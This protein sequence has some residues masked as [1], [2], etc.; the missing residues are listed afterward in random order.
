MHGSART[1][2]AVV[3]V[4]FILG[5][6]SGWWYRGLTSPAK[7]SSVVRI[8]EGPPRPLTNPAPPSSVTVQTEPVPQ[9]IDDKGTLNQMLVEQRFRDATAYYYQSVDA[10]LESKAR[11][12]PTVDA[13]LQ[14][15]FR[16]CES[17]TFLNLVDAWLATFYD[18]VP[19]LIALA[20]FQENQGQPEAAANTLLL[21]RTYAFPADDR[22]AVQQAL[23]RLTQRTDERLAGE[24]RW[25]ELLG[26]Y[27]FLAAIDFTA[28][29]FEL[30]RALLYRR[31]GEHV[32]A[33]E[34][35]TAL[36]TAD[37][38]SNPQLTAAIDRNI[39]ETT[40]ET[41]AVKDLSHAI[42][43]ERRGNG[44]L[45]NITLNDRGSLKLLV[46]TGASM[47]AISRETFR[48]LYQPDFRL[49]G[50]QLF[51]T[52]NGYTRGNV[53]RASAL[54]LGH[55]RL[56]DID[57]AVLDLQTLGDIDGLFGMNVLREFHFEID[58]ATGVMYLRRR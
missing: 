35:L 55:E 37:D 13:Y 15:C 23:D 41:K 20:E 1:Y 51:N 5:V 12:R 39:A 53:Y 14:H 57:V 56:N 22:S 33:T 9:E 36:K 30:R 25:V 7:R 32:R 47:T 45:V 11:L 16:N 17:E 26:Y 46:D 40:E 2:L 8:I 43:L 3:S 19:V 31:L 48:R 29:R 18:D 52:A 10:D 27:E 38:G 24:Q 49:V 54:N 4:V 50:T 58:H 44:Y 21:A 42:P 28:S 34:L 6:V